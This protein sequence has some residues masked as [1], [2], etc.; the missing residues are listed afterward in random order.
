VLALR[1][2]VGSLSDALIG[3]SLRGYLTKYDCSSGQL[4]PFICPFVPIASLPRTFVADVNP[5][6]GISKTDL[7]RFIT[8]AQES[9][10]LP[11]LSR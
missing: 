7:K 2:V 5:I 10:Q 11:I 6:G 3:R 4:E 9:F 8:W 1:D